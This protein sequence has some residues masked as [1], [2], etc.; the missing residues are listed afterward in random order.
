M[1][2]RPPLNA[3]RQAIILEMSQNP[4]VTK[5]KLADKLGV[6]ATA[7]DNNISFLRKN[8]YIERVGKAK[9]GYWKIL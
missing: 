6:S 7:I 3:R 4:Y 9:G 5:P 1:E 8:G 2:N